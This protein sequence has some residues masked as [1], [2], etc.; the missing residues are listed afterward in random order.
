VELRWRLGGL[1]KKGLADKAEKA[2][3]EVGVEK[4]ETTRLQGKEEEV[5]VE[6]VETKRA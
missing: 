4:V 2:E 1:S 3:E 6:K 5:E